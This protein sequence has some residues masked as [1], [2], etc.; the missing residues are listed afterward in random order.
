MFRKQPAAFSKV[1]GDLAETHGDKNSPG[2]DEWTR[3]K[4]SISRQ[5]HATTA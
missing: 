3:P 2:A 4:P 1:Y 5:K